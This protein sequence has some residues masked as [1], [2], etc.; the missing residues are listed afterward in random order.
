MLRGASGRSL[1]RLLARAEGVQIAGAVV[2][3][4]GADRDGCVWA[5]EFSSAETRTGA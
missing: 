3:R 4:V 2:R 5:C 1:G